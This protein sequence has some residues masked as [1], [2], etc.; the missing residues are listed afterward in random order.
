MLSGILRSPSIS[1]EKASSFVAILPS[2]QNLEGAPHHAGA[3][4]FAECADM[5]QA[6]RTI[7]GLEQHMGLAAG[8][9]ALDQLSR[10]FERPGLR[11]IRGFKE[12]GGKSGR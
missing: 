1:S 3:G 10:L 2:R 11:D 5:R 12:F 6:G 8:L 9:D 7:A 4:D